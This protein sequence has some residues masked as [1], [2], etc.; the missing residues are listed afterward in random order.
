MLDVPRQ[1]KALQQL[2]HLI[3]RIFL[4]LHVLRH[5]SL[6]RDLEET[7]QLDLVALKFI[8]Q[9]LAQIVEELL[10]SL[11]F[12]SHYFL[13]IHYFVLL[14]GI[15]N[16]LAFNLTIS[17]Y[18]LILDTLGL[19]RVQLSTPRPTFTQFTLFRIS[20]LKN[21]SIMLLL[22]ICHD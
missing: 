1:L 16:W 17:K 14:S 20:G 11:L 15:F 22:E 4:S 12:G 13:K 19:S 8:L 3:E 21:R 18:L 7:E 10:R 6:L 2:N 9:T 5:L